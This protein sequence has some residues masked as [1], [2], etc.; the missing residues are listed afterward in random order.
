MGRVVERLGMN[1]WL[2][3]CGVEMSG[4]VDEEEERREW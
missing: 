1:G 4:D 2:C 3:F